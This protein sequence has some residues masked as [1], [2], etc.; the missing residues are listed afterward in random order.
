MKVKKF[1]AIIIET[2]YHDKKQQKVMQI[3]QNSSKLNYRNAFTSCI[4]Q[5]RWL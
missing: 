2:T 5:N 3:L 1:G 4:S